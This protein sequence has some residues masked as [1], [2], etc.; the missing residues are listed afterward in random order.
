M[1]LSQNSLNDK[2]LNVT[3]DDYKLNET[4]KRKILS[5][6]NSKLSTKLNPL[7]YISSA[8]LFVYQQVFSEQISANCTYEISCSEF[9]KKA[10]EK[11]GIIKGSLIGF[12]QLSNCVTGIKYEYPDHLISNENKII[13]KNAF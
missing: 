1:G 11:H 6:K 13:N 4:N 7:T 12:H 2:I 8:L 5:L 10:I 9:T 3:F